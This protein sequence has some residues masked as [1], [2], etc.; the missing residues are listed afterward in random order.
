MKKFNVDDGAPQFPSFLQ[1]FNKRWY[2]NNCVVVYVCYTDCGV[3][4]ALEEAISLYGD[5]V[6]V[7]SGGHCYE[8]FVFGPDTKAIIDVTG[9]EH[10]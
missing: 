8:D 7:K 3:Q 4:E 9:L 2:A 5:E 6:K 1:G 10:R